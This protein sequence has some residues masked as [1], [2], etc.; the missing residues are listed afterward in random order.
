LINIFIID[1]HALMREV[2]RK[3]L[4]DVSGFKVI[5]DSETGAEGVKKIQELAPDLVILDYQLSDMNGLAVI[6][7][8]LADNSE[9]KILVLTA[10]TNNLIPL[11]LLQAGA[12]G[13]LSKNISHD[14]LIRAIKAIHIGQRVMSPALAKQLKFIEQKD[15]HE[16]PF[17][18]LSS[19][20]K[21]VVEQTLQGFSAKEIAD[22][23][24]VSV[25]TIHSF[26]GHIFEKLN[27]KNDV[28][29][30]LLAIRYG[31]VDA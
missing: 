1:D 11:Q 10:I 31:L 27:I 18:M 28:E 15:Q 29:L 20:E 21:L 4:E 24:Q 8:L 2:L 23:L 17:T 6:K 14:E 12:R 25:K 13:F 9:T 19:R 16:T 22:S 30:T 3:L 5:G 7:K 26:R